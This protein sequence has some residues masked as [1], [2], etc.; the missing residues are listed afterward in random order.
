L[1]GHCGSVTSLAF[2]PDRKILASLDIDKQ[3]FLWEVATGKQ[4]HQ[5]V[6]DEPFSS[7]RFSP[8]GK[9]LA[10]FGSAEGA[11]LWNVATGAESHRLPGHDGQFTALQFSPDSK[12]LVSAGRDNAIRLWDVNT[13][14]P[15]VAMTGHNAVVRTVE[16]T[17]DGKNLVSTSD[18]RTTRCWDAATGKEMTP[19]P[20]EIVWSQSAL[21]AV[22]PDPSPRVAFGQPAFVASPNGR[23]KVFG[24]P[25]KSVVFAETANNQERKKFTG[26]REPI[27][28]L[29]FSVDGGLAA[30][31]S[32]DGTILV[33]DVFG[34]ANTAPAKNLAPGQL[35]ELWNDLGAPDTGKAYR[36]IVAMAEAPGQTIP[37]LQDKLPPIVQPFTSDQIK[38]WLADLGGDQ[39]LSRE[40]AMAAL[41]QHWKDASTLLED[42]LAQQPPSAAVRRLLDQVEKKAAAPHPGAP[43]SEEARM[44]RSFEILETIDTPEARQLLKKLGEGPPI[45]PGCQ[46]AKAAWQRLNWQRAFRP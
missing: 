6:S 9:T 12:T 39:A 14:K 22:K 15:G 45:C 42:V 43:P 34:K 18:D 40:K 38:Q 46:E 37:F 11:I 10:T 36:A 2:S 5:I 32:Q 21:I 3:C 30:S 41:E 7:L 33:W 44:R 16:F 23:M 13:G 25:D 20:K 4:L 31:G 19:F 35:A 17:A 24:A 1:P 8:D 26:H 29:A 27:S 28:A